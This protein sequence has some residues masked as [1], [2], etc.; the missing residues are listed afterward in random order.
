MFYNFGNEGL[1]YKMVDGYPKYTELI[2]K[3]SEGLS[4]TQVM[5][6]YMRGH[7]NGPFVQDK[8][9][10]EQYYERPQQKEAMVNWKKNNFNKYIMPPV[11]PTPK[12]SEELS[13]ILNDLTTYTDEMTLKF[14]MGV[15]PLENFDQYV[16]QI[17][18]LGIDKALKIYQ[19]ALTRYNKR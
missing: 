1:T 15:E 18:K 17:K 9:Y 6:K 19:A 5:S 13:K 4:N 3:N 10:I 14:I 11:T 12:E 16:A 7:T 8:R 2:M